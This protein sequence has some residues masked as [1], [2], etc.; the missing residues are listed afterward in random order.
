MR[1]ICECGKALSYHN[2]PKDAPLA[3]TGSNPCKGYRPRAADWVIFKML[4]VKEAEAENKLKELAEKIYERWFYSGNEK[5]VRLNY[6]KALLK[7]IINE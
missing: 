5:V 1:T 4:Q 6:V 7:E 3:Y 2:H